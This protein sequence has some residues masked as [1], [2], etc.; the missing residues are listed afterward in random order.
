M[1]DSERF[2]TC[3]TCG[4]PLL[5]AD[6]FAGTELCGPCCLGEAEAVHDITT[7]CS[8]GQMIQHHVLQA[9]PTKCRHEEPTI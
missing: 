8:C 5:Q 4:V 2:G 9:P 6:G 3:I 1:G 7:R